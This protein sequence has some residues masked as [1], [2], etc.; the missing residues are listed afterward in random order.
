MLKRSGKFIF[1]YDPC[2]SVLTGF[3]VMGYMDY[4]VL[5]NVGITPDKNAGDSRAETA[6]RF[7]LG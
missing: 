1:P 2:R 6:Q 5:T 3:F 4:L 7:L